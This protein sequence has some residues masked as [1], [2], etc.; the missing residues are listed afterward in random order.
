MRM[1][2]K[3]RN[4]L[5]QLFWCHWPSWW[6]ILRC[7]LQ[8]RSSFGGL[9]LCLLQNTKIPWIWLI[10]T[11]YVAGA[12][13]QPQPSQSTKN[14]S[15]ASCDASLTERWASSCLLWIGSRQ[16]IFTWLSQIFFK[17]FPFS[18]SHRGPQGSL[19]MMKIDCEVTKK[20]ISH[21]SCCAKS[22]ARWKAP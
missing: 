15:S 2:K 11:E 7:L 18:E 10:F 6:H 3:S 20:T 14:V 8:W 5:F 22:W 19:A 16:W 17:T 12:G 13:Y 1:I 4:V 21:K 9:F